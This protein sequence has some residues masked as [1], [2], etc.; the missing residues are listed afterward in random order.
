MPWKRITLCVCA[1]VAPFL[2]PWFLAIVI[3]IAAALYVPLMAIAVGLIFDFLYYTHG[4]P[5]FT[6]FGL[7]GAGVAFLVHRFIKTRIMS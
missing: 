4:I 3:G 2:L 5:Y 7:V 6:I 1:I